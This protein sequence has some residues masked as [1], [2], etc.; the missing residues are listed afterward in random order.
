VSNS[1]PGTQGNIKTIIELGILFHRLKLVWRDSRTDSDAKCDCGS[2]VCRGCYLA[3]EN[4]KI[5]LPEAIA[6]CCLPP[7][8]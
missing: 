7:L 8:M 2:P 1:I 3:S 5:E 6:T 4:A